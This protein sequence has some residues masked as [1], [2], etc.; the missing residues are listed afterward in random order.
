[1]TTLQSKIKPFFFFIAE[2]RFVLLAVVSLG[3]FVTVSA[4]TLWPAWPGRGILFLDGLAAI[5]T[6]LV[7]KRAL[8]IRLFTPLR[9]LSRSVSGLLKGDPHGIARVRS[10]TEID[11]LSETLRQTADQLSAQ[12]KHFTEDRSQTDAILSGMMEGV[13]VL[14]QEGKIVLTN[15]AFETMFHLRREEFW[16]KYHYEVLRH[17]QLNLLIEEVRRKRHSIS[18]EMGLNLPHACFEI[19]A[20]PTEGASSWIVL[21]FHNITKIKRLEQV[22]SDF[23]ANISHE[24]NTPLSAVKGYLETLSDEWDEDPARAREYL[25]ILQRH[26]DRMQNIVS[27]LLQLSRIESGS[28]P[29]RKEPIQLKGYIDRIVLSLAPLAKKKEI[30]LQS[31]AGGDDFCVWADP[32]KM[33]RALVNL[34]DNALKYTPDKGQIVIEA[35]DQGVAITIAIRDTGIGIPKGDQIRIFERFYR[36]DRARSRELGGTGLGL[37]IVKHIVEAHEGQIAVKS[38]IG[39][40]TCFTITLPKNQTDRPVPPRG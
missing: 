27:D 26:T 13:V 23:V 30:L 24:L 17:H 18:S 15:S 36:V 7:L 34:L 8:Q 1:M 3:L 20:T 9:E 11:A 14:D 10:F 39:K 12:L 38:E 37:S 16:G 31:V 21:V 29:V 22:R 35:S 19:H 4:L 2:T 28:D 5:L 6:A 25:E 32:E 40:G 33:H